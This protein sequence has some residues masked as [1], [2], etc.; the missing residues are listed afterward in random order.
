MERY[1]SSRRS[2]NRDKTNSGSQQNRS[3]SS[4]EEDDRPMQMVHV[5]RSKTRERR[6]CNICALQSRGSATRKVVLCV[7]LGVALTACDGRRE[8]DARRD[9]LDHSDTKLTGQFAA[10][11]ST[12]RVTAGASNVGAKG[13]TTSTYVYDADREIGGI[14]DKYVATQLADPKA[15]K[16]G[17]GKKTQSKVKRTK[18]C[19]QICP[20]KFHQEL[21]FLELPQ[22]VHEA[23]AQRFKE[24]HEGRIEE[25]KAAAAAREKEMSGVSKVDCYDPKYTG[26]PKPTY[27]KVGKRGQG[28][29]TCPTLEAEERPTTVCCSICPDEN[30]P[31][32]DYD[33][34]TGQLTT[35][36]E[37]IVPLPNDC[38]ALN[39]RAKCAKDGWKAGTDCDPKRPTCPKPP[40]AFPGSDAPCCELCTSAFIPEESDPLNPSPS[41]K[42]TPRSYKADDNGFIIP[43][44]PPMQRNG[45]FPKKAKKDE[46]SRCCYPCGRDEYNRVP[47]DSPF[48]EPS[49]TAQRLHRLFYPL[50]VPSK[51]Q[52]NLR[53]HSPSGS[54][55]PNLP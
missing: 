24:W 27:Q 54:L 50:G 43:D 32:M 8:R 25:S 5:M 55:F 34:A 46:F 48:N 26:R 10:S 1:A 22:N 31:K 15:G 41:E 4:R 52:K 18:D 30:F 19:C 28:E 39:V 49:G 11:R 6:C 36:V 45:K 7:L 14:F 3:T 16:T 33:V 35:Q 38:K 2:S 21:V 44:L 9:N 20:Y 42:A 53:D 29:W 12:I 23:A 40:K 51:D 17:T 47:G 13:G 37:V